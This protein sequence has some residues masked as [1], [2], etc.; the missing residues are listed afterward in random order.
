MEDDGSRRPTL[1]GLTQTYTSLVEEF[2]TNEDVEA[3]RNDFG[4]IAQIGLGILRNQSRSEDE[5]L[6][7]AATNI[8]VPAAVIARWINDPRKT[9]PDFLAAVLDTL[10]TFIFDA[11]RETAKIVETINA[12]LGK[13]GAHDDFPRFKLLVEQGCDKLRLYGE[14]DGE[15]I[16]DE[17]QARLKQ[18]DPEL[19]DKAFRRKALKHLAEALVLLLGTAPP[20]SEASKPLQEEDALLN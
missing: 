2:R 4:S 7:Q 5:V 18:T 15:R 1:Y 20:E 11:A 17:L 8:G 19:I 16:A 6:E 9:H 13:K 12:T 3:A 10:R 14:E